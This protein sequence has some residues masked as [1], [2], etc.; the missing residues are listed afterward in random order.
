MAALGAELVEAD[1][2]NREQ[3]ANAFQGAWGAFVNTNSDDE[4]G[5]P[6]QPGQGGQ[7]LLAKAVSHPGPQVPRWAQ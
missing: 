2:F 6:V 5:V 4:V 7:Y 3:M 1:G